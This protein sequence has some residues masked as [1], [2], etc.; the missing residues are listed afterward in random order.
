MAKEE[1]QQA[2][3]RATG[4]RWRD[5]ADSAQNGDPYAGIA[6]GDGDDTG[7]AG[8]RVEGAVDAATGPGQSEGEHMSKL[9][10]CICVA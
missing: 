10:S 7:A 2:Q 6:L 1:T 4:R 5:A 9:L 8:S 3:D